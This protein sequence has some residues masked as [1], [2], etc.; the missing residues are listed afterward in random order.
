MSRQRHVEQVGVGELHHLG[1][2]G[3]VG[4]GDEQHRTDLAGWRRVG[5]AI[6]E[7]R[8]PAVAADLDAAVVRAEAHQ[9]PRLGLDELLERVGPQVDLGEDLRLP[10]SGDGQALVADQPGALQLHRVRLG[11]E[12]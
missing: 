5:I 4:R 3:L 7:H 9:R 11:R 12:A 10:D 2:G 1:G 8:V 6:A